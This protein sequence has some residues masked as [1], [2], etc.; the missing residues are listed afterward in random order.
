[1]VFLFTFIFTV[2]EQLLRIPLLFWKKTLLIL[3]LLM[4]VSR[5]MTPSQVS[6]CVSKICCLKKPVFYS[7]L[8]PSTLRLEQDA[9][10]RPRLDL[11]M[12]LML[13]RELQVQI[14]KYREA[15]YANIPNLILTSCRFL[16]FPLTSLHKKGGNPRILAKSW[17]EALLQNLELQYERADKDTEYCG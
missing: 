6:L 9:I 4:F 11:K 5:G 7:T 14:L 10:V 2:A 16:H 17:D 8:E 12:L 3:M 15:I 13:F 1:M